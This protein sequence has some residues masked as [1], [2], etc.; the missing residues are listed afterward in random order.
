MVIHACNFAAN[1]GNGV[2]SS[3]GNT[4]D[5]TGNW[6]GDAAGPTAPAG[7]GV[8]ANVNYTPFL[9]TPVG[10]GY[11]SPALS[12]AGSPRR[13]PVGVRRLSETRLPQ[14]P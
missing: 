6:W 3:L 4:V 14:I 9:T 8:S 7:D 13:Q 5:A 10:L 12:V 1:N 2:E 11:G